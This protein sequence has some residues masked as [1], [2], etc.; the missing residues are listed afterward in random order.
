MLPDS[1]PLLKTSETK[2]KVNDKQIKLYFLAVYILGGQARCV[3]REKGHT[4]RCLHHS[5]VFAVLGAPSH[6]QQSMQKSALLETGHREPGISLLLGRTQVVFRTSQTGSWLGCVHSETLHEVLHQMSQK[7]RKG[8][9]PSASIGRMKVLL[10]K[11]DKPLEPNCDPVLNA[12]RR[13]G[14]VK[15]GHD[16]MLAR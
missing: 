6:S 9:G 1:R 11:V 2:R 8:T 4:T 14:V 13:H 16:R 12:I 3:G 5:V 7:P 10:Q 15:H